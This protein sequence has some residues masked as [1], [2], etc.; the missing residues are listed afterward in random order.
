MPLDILIPFWGDLRL[1][2]ETISS[3]LLQENGDWE[4]TV[5]DD[6]YPDPAVAAY[7]ETVD[8]PRIRYLRYEE[9]VGI[10]ENFSRCA[11]LARFERVVVLGCDDVLLPNYVDVV[12]A[13]H[14]A[15]P[16]VDIIQPGVQVI[17]EHGRVQLT[18]ADTVKRRISMPRGQG[19]RVLVGEPLAA[20]LLRGNWMYW[21]SLAFRRETLQRTP[22]RAE[23][24]I[25]QDLGLVI[26]MVGAG[27]S[28]MIEPEVCFSYRRHSASASMAQLP[29][30]SRFDGE[31][32]YFAQAAEQMDA[33]GWRRAARAAR[34]HLTSRA[35]AL[36][37][38]PRA[39]RTGDT[40]IARRLLE[41]ATRP[42]R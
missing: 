10:T 18:L 34:H 33:L 25:I 17:D 27:A 12:L 28:L 23:L 5:V 39:V 20:S 36:T 38:L 37:L 32:A 42:L 30:G 14:R 19:R 41:H 4:L 29:D 2:R 31:R 6:A 9:N 13:A 7:F 22:F 15:A 26:D 11:Q 21:P 35:H 3:V 1:L 40:A 24:A 16:D 8:D